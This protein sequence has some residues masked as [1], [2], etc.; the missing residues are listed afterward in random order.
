MA[1]PNAIGP[2]QVSAPAANGYVAK[3][4]AARLRS[5]KD[6]EVIVRHR[7]YITD[8]IPAST[9]T[10]AGA[11]QLLVSHHINPGNPL[12]FP[13][14]S[15]IAT[16]FESYKFKALRFIYEPQ[17]ATS[18]AG[19]VMM[20]IDY[21]DA[22]SPPDNKTQFMSFKNAT[23]SPPWFA[24]NN[25]S[26]PSDLSK[27]STYF[28]RN[29][30]QASSTDSR[31]YDT[32]QFYL[33]YEGP[34]LAASFYA[35]ELYVE[36]DVCLM[37]PALESSA[38][39]GSVGT[40]SNASSIAAL[41]DLLNASA[42]GP[43]PPVPLAVPSDTGSLFIGSSVP[44]TYQVTAYVQVTPAFAG[45]NNLLFDVATGSNA[46]LGTLSFRTSSPNPGTFW[47]ISQAVK[48][49]NTTD[50]IKLFMTGVNWGTLT[51]DLCYVILSPLSAD[52]AGVPAPSTTSMAIL[53]RQSNVARIEGAMRA[54]KADRKAFEE[55]LA[56]ESVRE[57]PSTW[58]YSISKE[59]KQ[60]MDDLADSM[61]AKCQLTKV[62]CSDCPL[63]QKMVGLEY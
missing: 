58:E 47:S 54:F 60:V 26:A 12:L 28:V 13:W 10:T 17:C 38:L 21:D 3:T 62:K 7:E 14:L 50:F 27:R 11:F 57:R 18:S 23:R 20:V 53:S 49:P 24:G 42:Q 15:E 34:A 2:L 1:T 19:T 4:Q 16:R 33:A 52:T 25:E 32:G 40:T 59:K 30:S 41:A 48:F 37:T 36:Y 63:R 8:V 61:Q 51:T 6:G 22:D 45:V 29:S 56:P 31:L 55:P 9:G 39:S 43:N 46:E 5:G 44:G 35:G